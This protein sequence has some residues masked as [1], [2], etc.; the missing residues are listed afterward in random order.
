MVF[1]AKSATERPFSLTLITNAPKSWTA[2]MKTVPS[3]IHKNTGSQPQHI[4]IHGPSIG[5]RPAIEVK[6][7]PKRICLLV[8]T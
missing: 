1:L 3:T 6:W 4:A 8:G 2:P 7:C 5:A